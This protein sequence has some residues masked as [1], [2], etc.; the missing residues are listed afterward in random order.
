MI[1]ARSFEDTSGK[2][3]KPACDCPLRKTNCPIRVA[4]DELLMSILDSHASPL[5][6][7]AVTRIGTP[8]PRLDHVMSPGSKPIGY[9]C[10]G[11]TVDKESHQAR[12]CSESSLS[13]EIA[14]CA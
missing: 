9:E 5:Q 1:I 2:R 11:A 10:P 12:M 13:C 7:Y 14:A 8:L 3:I 4:G 6:Y